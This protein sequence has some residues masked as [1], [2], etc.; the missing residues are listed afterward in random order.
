MARREVVPVGEGGDAV[1]H[2]G[3]VDGVEFGAGAEG[4]GEGEGE[5]AAEPP[6]W[7]RIVDWHPGF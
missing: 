6:R 4:G 3:F 7:A 2:E 5:L 1:G